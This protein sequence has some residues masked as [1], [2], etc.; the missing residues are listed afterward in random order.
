MKGH[1]SSMP[2]RVLC[3]LAWILV[4]GWAPLYAQVDTATITGIV[5]DAQG[6]VLPGATVVATH[7]DTN[8]HVETVT[9]EAGVYRTSPLP[10]GTYSVSVTLAG[11]KTETHQGITL[12]VQ[13]VARVDFTLQVGDISEE[14]TITGAAPLLETETSSIGQVI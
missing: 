2:R 14:V 3:V 8:Q 11:F 13:Q 10:I 6:A 4:V 7:V 12:N 9:N 5:R 1:V